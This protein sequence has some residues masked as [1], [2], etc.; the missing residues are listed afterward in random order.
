[1][2]VTIAPEVEDRIRQWI[3]SG[4]YPDADAVRRDALHLLEERDRAQLE[5][6]RGLLQKGL[7]SEA[8]GDLIEVNDQ[9]WADLDRRVEER[10]R[11]GESPNPDVCP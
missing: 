10:F 11:R 7:D 6:L 2:S 8:R 5:H 3:A 1:M 9:F 4:R